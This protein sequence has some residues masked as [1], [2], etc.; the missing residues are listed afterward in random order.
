MM[1]PVELYTRGCDLGR[2]TVELDD[3]RSRGNRFGV[4]A[5]VAVDGLW[6]TVTAGGLGT[7]SGSTPTQFFATGDAS[8]VTVSVVWP[9]GEESTYTNVPT[10]QAIVVSR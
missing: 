4:G 10:D 8:Q 2:V 6:S 9:D 7:Y 3:T 1:G 5:R